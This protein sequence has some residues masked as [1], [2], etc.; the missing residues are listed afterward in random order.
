MT[1]DTGKALFSISYEI[2]TK[3]LPFSA[4]MQLYY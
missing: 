2:R 4:E 3:E 1:F